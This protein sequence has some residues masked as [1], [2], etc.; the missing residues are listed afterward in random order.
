MFN[1]QLDY[2][3]IQERA[4][5][6]V[7]RRQA[8]RRVGLFVINV[9]LYMSLNAVTWGSL[10]TR[11]YTYS[12]FTIATMFVLSVG[13]TVSLFLHGASL[14]ANSERASQR[15]RERAIVREIAREMAR[16]GLDERDI[17]TSFGDE[18]AKRES[19]LTIDDDELVEIHDWDG[20]DSR[21]NGT[22][23]G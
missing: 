18:K 19:R 8:R 22:P 7:K 23:R 11:E 17:Y 21:Q 15:R 9:L 4:D 20:N 1:D 13:W 14:W 10:L 16:L 3:A 6:A 5:A 12:D 2:H